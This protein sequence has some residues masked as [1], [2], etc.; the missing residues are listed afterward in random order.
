MSENMSLLGMYLMKNRG[1]FIAIYKH[2]TSEPLYIKNTDNLNRTNITFHSIKDMEEYTQTRCYLLDEFISDF[3]EYLE[4]LGILVEQKVINM[5]EVQD[6]NKKPCLNFKDFSVTM[7]NGC[8][9][10]FKNTNE[11][12]TFVSGH[13]E[14][15]KRQ[16]KNKS[17]LKNPTILEANIKYKE[18]DEVL[19]ETNALLI[20]DY[21]AEDFDIT[22]DYAPLNGED[23]VDYYNSF[24]SQYSVSQG[25]CINENSFKSKEAKRNAK[26]Q[27]DES[28]N[29]KNMADSERYLT[30]KGLDY[31]SFIRNFEINLQ[32]LYFKH[33]IQNP[34]NISDKLPHIELLK[35]KL[36]IFSRKDKDGKTYDC[37]FFIENNKLILNKWNDCNKEEIISR[38]TGR[39]DA[40]VDIQM[41][42]EKFHVYK[43]AWEKN[44]ELII[45]KDSILEIEE[46]PERMMYDEAK[47]RQSLESRKI[48]Y[49]KTTWAKWQLDANFP[50][51]QV[52]EFNNFILHEVKELGD[53]S[54]DELRNSNN[55]EYWKRILSIF[56]I[57]KETAFT[58]FISKYCQI[59][60]S[61]K[62]TEGVFKLY[63]GIWYDSQTL[64]Y[65]AGSKTTYNENQEK[66]HQ[67]RRVAEIEGYFNA[68]EFFPL[69]DVEFVRYGGYTVLP[70]PFAIIRIY[71]KMS[72]T[73]N[74]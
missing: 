51:K 67:M 12:Q 66:G 48:K 43:G 50:I 20:M 37:A 70:Y 23:Y 10:T 41:K 29:D 52:K 2:A 49:P 24:K 45:S 38:V 21:S 32:Q 53:L 40:W 58:T 57:S 6:D 19:E 7:V 15:A 71:E 63:K 1:R 9:G 60:I 56:E 17:R 34:N 27:R 46:I 55:K 54:Y 3:K 11:L 26:K 14:K 47:V 61:G 73:G 18:L 35:N 13:L 44:Y 42:R 74:K 28:K 8:Y 62:K 22:D 30:Y 4:D 39:K 25:F 72:N 69:L 59:P 65:Y 5:K 33:I 64:Q 36:F 31:E 16:A 68:K